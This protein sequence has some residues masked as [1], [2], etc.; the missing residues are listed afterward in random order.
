MSRKIAVLGAGAIGGSVGADLA[1]A[2]HDVVLID[3]W[4]AHI[5]AMKAHGLR[6]VLP[7]SELCVPVRAYHLCDVCSLN[8]AFDLVFM[9]VKSYDSRWMA[10]FIKPYL[11]PDGVLVCMQNSMNDE[12]VAPIVGA[13]RDIGCVLELSGEVFTPGVVTRNTKH[14][15]TWFGFGELDGTTTPRVGEIAEL[16][17]CVG[18]TTATNNIWG[19]KWTKLTNNTMTLAPTGLLGTNVWEVTTP[20]VLELCVKLGKETMAVG[21]ALGY[22]AEIILGIRADELGSSQDDI[23]KKYLE[24]IAKAV[25]KTARSCV[26]QDHMKHRLSEVGYI[27][28]L[29]VEKGRQVNIPTPYNAAVTEVTRRIER[30]ELKPDRSNLALVV[31]LA[32]G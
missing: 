9:T 13:T 2:G 3:Q 20:E 7:N 24:T 4:P 22:K 6:V 29:V 30:G 15:V 32:G 10:E 26:I 14:E 17:R 21:R 12:W 27:N 31:Q 11:K 28:G 1:N 18:K 25:G 8:T 16:M 5:E 19:A 23:L